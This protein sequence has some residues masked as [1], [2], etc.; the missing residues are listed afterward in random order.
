MKTAW[1]MLLPFAA[2]LA[3]LQAEPS[4]RIEA[5]TG[6]ENRTVRGPVH[7]I[8]GAPLRLRVVGTEGPGIRWWQIVPDT[9]R[10][11][12]NANHPWEQK[13]Y[14]WV[15]FGRIHYGL[16]EL[17]E[18]RDLA[19]VEVSVPN[20]FEGSSHSPYY[21]PEIGSFWFQVTD[22]AG[23]RSAGLEENRERGL[24][25]AVFRLTIE[26][27]RTFLGSLTGYFNVPGLFGCTPDQS[28]HYIGIDCADVLH[29]AHQRWC[30]KGEGKDINVTWIVDHWK[31]VASFQIVAGAPRAIVRWES[32]VR[33][34]D[35]IAV[36]Y[37][38]GKAFQHIGALYEDANRN[39][40]LDAPD[41]IVHAGPHALHLSWLREGGFD[42]EVVILRPPE[43]E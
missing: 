11:Y 42:G 1:L 34:G 6:Q 41:A 19:E 9:A 10:Y 5:L 7:V 4:L 35:A 30:G 20:C 31:Q 13:P 43:R 33:P 21:H 24:S 26:K 22:A 40:V 17:E 38:P 27:D 2:C 18:W 37:T 8:A 16:V 32:E 23:R 39:G 12:K 29:A 28:R 15:G 14:E 3:L 25:P 36:R